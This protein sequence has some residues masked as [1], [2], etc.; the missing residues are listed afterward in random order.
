MDVGGRFAQSYVGMISATNLSA[1]KWSV[2]K[3]GDIVVALVGIVT[4]LI[5]FVMLFGNQKKKLRLPQGPRVPEIG[6]PGSCCC[7]LC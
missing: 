5:M 4:L 3:H 1:F 7:F 6:L 2:A